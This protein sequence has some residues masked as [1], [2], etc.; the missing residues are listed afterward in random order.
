MQVIKVIQNK[1]KNPTLSQ[2][3][4]CILKV[5][6]LLPALPAQLGTLEHTQASTYMLTCCFHSQH[7]LSIL[8]LKFI[9]FTHLS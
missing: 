3:T 5:V 7:E 9:I 8:Q 1:T 6:G 4:S 2:K